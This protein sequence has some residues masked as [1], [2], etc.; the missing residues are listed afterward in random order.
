MKLG[1]L[2]VAV[3]VMMLS[4]ISFAADKTYKG[5]IMDSACAAMGSH[6]A[7][8]KQDP[9]IKTAKDCT[10][11]C[12]A[13]GAKY[14]LYDSATKTVYQLDD[15]KKPMAFAGAKVAVTGT[16]DDSTKTIHV[17]KIKAS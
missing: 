13:H 2:G 7:M 3:A 9:S 1:W 6:D 11:G 5:E 15:Q 4:G 10:N 17:T 14:V 12:V 16:L 8:M